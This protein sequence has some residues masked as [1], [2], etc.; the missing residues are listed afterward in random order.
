MSRVLLIGIL[1]PILYPYF[2]SMTL[3]I[4]SMILVE[5]TEALYF[6]KNN[7]LYGMQLYV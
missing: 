3:E 5:P 2:E 7:D 4:L 1:D 6:A